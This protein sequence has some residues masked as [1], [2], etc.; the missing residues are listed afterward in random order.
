MNTDEFVDQLSKEISQSND[1][2]GVLTESDVDETD[3]PT[4]D[5]LGDDDESVD[6][7][8]DEVLDNWVEGI[9]EAPDD[10]AS[11]KELVSTLLRKC[12]ALISLIK[13]STILT[14]YFDSERRNFSI[15][16]NLSIDVRTRWNSTF[17]LID[18]LIVLRDVV[19][20]LFKSKHR[21]QIKQDQLN[22]L[23]NLELT[24]DDWIKLSQLHGILQP[25]FHATRAMSGRGYPTIGFAYYLIIRLKL[26]LQSQSKNDNRFCNA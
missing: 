21:L 25:F 5:G 10:T 24:S 26:F 8:D 12:R 1:H 11:D 7:D 17:Y 16:R 2:M 13:C 4:E 19:E 18:S 6:I 3:L 22:K 20:R 23:S 15:K 14:A 9:D